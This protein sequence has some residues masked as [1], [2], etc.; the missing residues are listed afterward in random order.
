MSDAVST[1]VSCSPAVTFQTAL[2]NSFRR[3][4]EP[5]DHRHCPEPNLT[6][7]KPRCR[8]LPESISNLENRLLADQ[9]QSRLPTRYIQ[10]IRQK[11]VPTKFSKENMVFELRQQQIA[12]LLEHLEEANSHRIMVPS[13]E[14]VLPR[15]TIIGIDGPVSAP[16]CKKIQVVFE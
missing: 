6:R 10:N 7:N 3:S 1:P 12:L 4:V 2:D 8:L 14:S 13:A 15:Q 9:E 11:G 5:V 16:C